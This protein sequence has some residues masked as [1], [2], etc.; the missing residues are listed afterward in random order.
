MFVIGVTGHRGLTAAQM[1]AVEAQVRAFLGECAAANAIDTCHAGGIAL[2]TSL[3]AGADTLCAKCAIDMGMRL[4]AVLPMGA[5]VY[6]E[7]FSQVQARDF[8][9]LLSLADEVVVPG[10]T[11]GIGGDAVTSASVAGEV[12]VPGI[13]GGI[14]SI[15]SEGPDPG[16][17]DFSRGQRYRMASRYIVQHC[18]ML[19]AIWDGVRRDTRD[20]AGTWETVKMAR[21]YG[22]EV[23]WIR[24]GLT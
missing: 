14:G 23:A 17:A 16:S 24:T 13:M 10:R 11:G 7:D 12:V 19:L 6:R 22:R 8:D 3:A 9:G 4:I 18:D 20:G 21:Q 2:M 1:S 15:S 5:S